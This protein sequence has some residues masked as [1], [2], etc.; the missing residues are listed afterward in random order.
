VAARLDEAWVLSVLLVEDDPA[1]ARRLTDAL[2]QYEGVTF[3]V[4]QAT[5]VEDGLRI[6][7]E[8]TFDVMVLDLSLPEGHGLTAFLRAKEAAP[9]VPIVVVTGEDDES[10]ALDSVG[11]GAQEYLVKSAAR[12][13]PRTLVNAVHRHRVLRELRSARQREHYLATH[14]SMT[15]LLNRHAFNDRLREAI[16]RAERGN[17]RLG[18]LFLDLDDFKAIN[19]SLGH[20]AGDD[21]LR[22]FARRLDRSTRRGDPTARFG[23]DEF[24]V[25]VHDDPGP[26]AL[27][28]VASRILS[29]V[30]EP[31]ALLGQ[32]YSLGLSIGI[33]IFPHDGRDPD[34]LVRNADT[35]MYQAKSRGR[36]RLCFYSNGMNAAVAERL[37][38][39]HQIRQ[40]T[41]R[42]EFS[43][44]YQPQLDLAE[45][46]VTGVEA[47]VR[48]R[49]PD[50]GLATA[51]SFVPAAER[52]GLI[53]S[54]GEWVL[55]QACRDAVR[56]AQETGT[57][58]DLAVNVSHQQLG[59]P[60]FPGIVEQALE[61]SGLDPARLSLE[62][63]ESVAMDPGHAI[64][65]LRLL[66]RSGV[67]VALD[68]FGTGY[69]HLTALRALPVDVLKIDRS[70]VERVAD[71]RTDQAIV[72]AVLAL[73][74]A[75][76]CAAVA[77]GVET[78]AQLRALAQLGCSRVQGFLFSEPLPLDKLVTLLREPEPP[79]A[80]LL[81]ALGA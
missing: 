77:E 65:T 78:Q 63:T 39:S 27:E 15:G 3:H 81:R 66:R 32:D 68:D 5:G 71:E 38:V 35:A 59:D 51:A 41:H 29:I 33:A 43:L 74:R 67:R 16:A 60:R 48:W 45:G 70:F 37:R 18:L 47:L 7:R 36:N 42:G 20:P 4:E 50:G 72:T 13:L 6:L 73:A 61:A 56:I 23:G 34:V 17:E 55:Q 12:F 19:D 44:H 62:I 80:E 79:W 8:Q 57:R 22:A 53:E 14:D 24:T 76:G 9:S 52:L 1:D 30:E 75:V 31:F 58:L 2:A 46:E 28:T 21:I 49:D 11:L 40:A 26:R 64:E 69:A 54:I 10:L 25:L